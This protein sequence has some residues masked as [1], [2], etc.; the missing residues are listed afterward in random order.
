MRNFDNLGVYKSLLLAGAAGTIG[1]ARFI[2]AATDREVLFSKNATES[3]NLVAQ[4]WGRANLGRGDVV[5]ISVPAIEE[6]RGMVGVVQQALASMRRH[7]E[8]RPLASERDPWVKRHKG[9]FDR[10]LVDA[11][12]GV[13]PQTK[14]VVGKALG[15]GL[16]ELDAAMAARA[17]G[18]GR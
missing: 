16:R 1:L 8:T 4:S 17:P 12:E 13:L 9:K 3:L 2:G 18:S 5:E 10:V 6:L 7:I 14:F 15:R 11:A